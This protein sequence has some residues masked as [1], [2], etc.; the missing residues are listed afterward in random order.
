MM[1]EVCEQ[2]DDCKVVYDS[3]KCPLCWATEKIDDLQQEAGGL[4]ERVADLEEELKN[5]GS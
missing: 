2:H 4:Q 1:M 5:A 3:K